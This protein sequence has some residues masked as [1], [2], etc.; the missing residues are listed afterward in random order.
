MTEK[1]D[2]LGKLAKEDLQVLALSYMYA[3]N[4]H[5]YGED[6]TKAICSAVQNVAMMDKAYQRGYYDAM[7]KN[8]PNVI[9]AYNDGEAFILD[10]LR[11]EIQ[12]IQVNRGEYSQNYCDGCEFM[13]EHILEIIDKY[14][15]GFILPLTED[16]DKEE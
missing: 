16:E 6:L 12:L 10:I 11:A 9:K 5:M 1:E 13:I 14:R 4:L 7:N 15:E 3:K 2:L 8:D